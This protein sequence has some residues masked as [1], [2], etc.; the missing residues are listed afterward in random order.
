MGSH[1]MCSA[2]ISCIRFFPEADKAGRLIQ[3][4]NTKACKYCGEAQQLKAWKE[5][6]DAH[7]VQLSVEQPQSSQLS[8]KSHLH[9]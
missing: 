5:R 3:M 7:F 2:K 8:L 6:Q 4:H 1:T 9:P